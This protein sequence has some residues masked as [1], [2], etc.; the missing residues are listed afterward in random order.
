MFQDARMSACD[1]KDSLCCVA[2][3]LQTD[4]FGVKYAC[5]TSTSRVAFSELVFVPF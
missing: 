5:A 1:W 4:I 2:L 3:G